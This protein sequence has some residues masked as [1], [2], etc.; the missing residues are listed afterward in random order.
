M[1]DLT[2]MTS[3][4]VPLWRVSLINCFNVDM[5]SP[6]VTRY[7]SAITYLTEKRRNPPAERSLASSDLVGIRT[8]GKCDVHEISLYSHL[9]HQCPVTFKHTREEHQRSSRRDSQSSIYP[10]VFPAS[11]VQD[12]STPRRTDED[13]NADDCEPHA[14]AS[15]NQTSI[16]RQS[17]KNCWWY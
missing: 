5:M 4:C 14:H 7:A 13:T 8:P 2:R 6:Y 3:G 9:L 1:T 11:R 17:N 16:G 15:A 10:N 12:P